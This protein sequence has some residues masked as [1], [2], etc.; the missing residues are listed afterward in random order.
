M[1]SERERKNREM[2]V[3]F[4]QENPDLPI[5]PMVDSEID[6]DAGSAYWDGI[7]G[8]TRI[9]EYIVGEEAVHFKDAND[10][11]GMC[12]TLFDVLDTEC[13]S[14]TEAMKAYAELPWIK[15]IIVYIEQ[16]ER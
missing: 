1:I 2:L 5:V 8:E 14:E 16:P 4:M 12:N 7:L 15:A 13:Y 6:F 9:G 10:F 11:D 3:T